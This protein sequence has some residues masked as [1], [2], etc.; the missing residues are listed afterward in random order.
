[1]APALSTTKRKFNQILDSISNASSSSIVL[2]DGRTKNVLA[3]TLSE[4]TEPSVKKPRL[5]RPAPA[6]LQSNLAK[7]TAQLLPSRRTASLSGSS[8]MAVDQ[9]KPPNFAPC[10]RA[11]FLERLK[12]FRHVDKWAWKPERINEVQWAKRGWRCVDSERVRCLGGCEKEV[13]IRLGDEPKENEKGKEISEIE[14]QEWRETARKQ[15][16]DKYT[17]MIITGHD[18]GC[19]WRR[20]GCDGTD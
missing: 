15:L 4:N 9:L 14:D 19:L 12:T 3:T 18:S 13:L 5:N 8:A 6:L 11:Q 1:M 17:E 10:D 7:S 2:E 20:R 16:I